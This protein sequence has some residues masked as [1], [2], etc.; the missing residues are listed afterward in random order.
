MQGIAVQG[1][2]LSPRATGHGA[3]TRQCGLERGIAMHPGP[4]CFS[5]EAALAERGR[6]Q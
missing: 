1:V 4:L 3:T 2:P 6:T 5:G